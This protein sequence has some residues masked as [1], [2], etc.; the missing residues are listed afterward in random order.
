[1]KRKSSLERARPSEFYNCYLLRVGLAHGLIKKTLF[2]QNWSGPTK[3]EEIRAMLDPDF[4]H[5]LR[6]LGSRVRD[7]RPKVYDPGHRVH[8]PKHMRLAQDVGSRPRM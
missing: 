8:D 1:M 3:S 7:S 2:L 6:D 4:L 5:M